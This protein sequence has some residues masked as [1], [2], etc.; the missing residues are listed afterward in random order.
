M[1]LI[2]RCH[3]S[4]NTLV[5][6]D[7]FCIKSDKVDYFSIDRIPLIGNLLRF[8]RSKIYWGKKI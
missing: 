5:Q 8:K 3:P 4:A 2:L 1:W 6:K 7:I